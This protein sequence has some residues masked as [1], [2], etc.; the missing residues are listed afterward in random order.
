MYDHALVSFSFIALDLY[1]LEQVRGDSIMLEEARGTRAI[2][3]EAV[4]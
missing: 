2:V 1:L 4:T 3:I